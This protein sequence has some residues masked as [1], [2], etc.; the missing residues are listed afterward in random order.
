VELLVV[1]GIIALLVAILLPA[2][3]KAR[4]SAV[5]V[6]CLSQQKQIVQAFLLYAHNNDNRLPP[7]M[8]AHTSDEF[9]SDYYAAWW[10]RYFAGKFLNI[11]TRGKDYNPST[12]TQGYTASFDPKAA[13]IYCPE[14]YPYH[15]VNSDLGYGVN[16]YQGAKVMGNKMNLI[17]H[18]AMVVLLVDVKSG[19]IWDKFYYNQ[20]GTPSGNTPPDT[21]MVYY[22]HMQG[23]STVVSFVDGHSE[24]FLRDGKSTTYGFNTGLH[25]AFLSKAISP[26]ASN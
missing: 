21:A 20:A 11:K 26:V 7:S 5:Q 17:R 8:V 12:F 24:T 1:I 9:N 18:P 23:K 16:T 22:R 19:I 6:Q 4:A 25:A 14:Y 10:N 15:G 2:L 13:H 3:N